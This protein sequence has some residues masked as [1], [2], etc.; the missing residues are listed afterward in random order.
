MI[1]LNCL[2][3]LF[4]ESSEVI[5]RFAIALLSIH[6]EELL[7]RDNFEDIMDYIKNSLP[8]INAD[9]LDKVT[10]DVSN[11]LMRINVEC[12]LEANCG[13]M[14]Y[15]NRC[16][17]QVFS[18]DIKKQLSEYHVEYHVLQEEISTT[19]HYME[20]LNREKENR[21]Q[22]ENKLEVRFY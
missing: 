2:D 22:L 5:F 11:R 9:T 20:S 15:V 12:I 4:L 10:R 6:K 7:K 14:I 19:Q 16:D 1:F 17:C 21:N 8:Q 3:L 13:I 18:M